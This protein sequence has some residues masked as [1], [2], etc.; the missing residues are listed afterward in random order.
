MAEASQ[1]IL[2]ADSNLDSA[3]APSKELD[4]GKQLLKVR[5]FA[6]SLEQFLP[7]ATSEY[8]QRPLVMSFPA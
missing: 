4:C 6:L 1:N 7:M 2:K 5:P 3:E 8:Y